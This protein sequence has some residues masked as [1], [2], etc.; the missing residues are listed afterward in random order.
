MLL[1]VVEIAAEA[2]HAVWRFRRILADRAAVPLA[3]VLM[4]GIVEHLLTGTATVAP[5]PGLEDDPAGTGNGNGGGGGPGII[6][7]AY[8]LAS[9]PFLVSWYRF[10]IDGPLGL[11]G[12]P[13]FTF[14]RLEGRFLLWAV[15]LALVVAAPMIVAG[16]VA[17]PFASGNISAHQ[18]PVLPLLLAVFFFILLILA[19]LRLSLIF[20]AVAVEEPASFARAWEMSKGNSL[21]MLA[22]AAAVHLPALFFG[23]IL[24]LMVI[25]FG[26][27]FSVLLFTDLAISFTIMALG[28]T[29]FAEAYKRL[30]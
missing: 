21:R 24:Q 10:I 25:G 27:P 15:V 30:R 26:L 12:R 2:Y 17:I 19:S 13:L 16:A 7:I 20:P 1:P 18:L 6:G 8:F 29:M 23:G 22:L 3:L 28:A 4:A 14:G 11:E 9:L 5:P